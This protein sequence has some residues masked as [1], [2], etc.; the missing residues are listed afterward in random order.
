MA[1]SDDCTHNTDAAI[2]RKVHRN[3]CAAARDDIVDNF[4]ITPALRAQAP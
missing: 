2:C 4:E 1:C 3:G